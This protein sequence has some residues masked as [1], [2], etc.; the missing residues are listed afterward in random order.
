MGLAEIQGNKKRAMEHLKTINGWNDTQADLYVK[1]AF[2]KW[3]FFSQSEWDLDIS[4]ATEWL[5][6][7]DVT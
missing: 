6:S 5:E 7:E 4:L 1:V 3:R 2:M